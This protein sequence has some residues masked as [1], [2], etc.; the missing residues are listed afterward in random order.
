MAKI[1]YGCRVPGWTADQWNGRVNI[2]F[3]LSYNKNTNETTVIFTADECYH[4]Y[5]GLNGWGTEA[6]TG[7]TI[8]AADNTSDKKTGWL[9]T[10]GYTTGGLKQFNATPNNITVKHS[11]AIG[12]KSIVIEASTTIKVY[13]NKNVQSTGTG[14]Y[15][16]TVALPA[17][18]VGQPTSFTTSAESIIVPTGSI[19]LSWSGA[20]AGIN[21][22]IIGYW[23]YWKE[24]SKPTVSSYGG[25]AKIDSTAT[26]GSHIFNFSSSARTRGSTI[27][28]AILVKGFSGENYEP[29]LKDGPTV[30]INSLPA[31]PALSTMSAALPSTA[32][33]YSVKVTAGK[34][35]DSSQIIQV[36]LAADGETQASGT[37]FS[38]KDAG[39]FTFYSF[40]GLENSATGTSITIIRNTKP[41]V[42]S[43]S[44]VFSASVNTNDKT[45]STAQL[46]NAD[47]KKLT[48][49]QW[50]IRSASTS[51][52]VSSA[53]AKQI[54]TGTI[55]NSSSSGSS[56]CTLIINP[57]A[58]S[59][60]V[61]PGYYYQI[62]VQLKDEYEYSDIK[63][64]SDI[65]QI[66][67]QLSLS[68]NTITATHSETGMSATYASYYRAPKINLNWKS[69]STFP[70]GLSSL[71]YSVFYSIDAGSSWK[72][73]S[74]GIQS[75]TANT[76]YTPI[77]DFSS[78]G[79]G[80]FLAK[81][82]LYDKKDGS[83]QRLETAVS[84]K[85][86][87]AFDPQWPV[88]FNP[89]LAYTITSDD[90]ND[91]RICA[92]PNLKK[93]DGTIYNIN[94]LSL[95]V[96]YPS[97][98]NTILQTNKTDLQ[99]AIYLYQDGS[100]ASA[101]VRAPQKISTISSVTEAGPVDLDI[102]YEELGKCYSTFLDT[103]DTKWIGPYNMSIVVRF[104]DAFG[105][106]IDTPKMSFVLDFREK[107]QQITTL[108]IGRDGVLSNDYAAVAAKRSANTVIFPTGSTNAERSILVGEHLIIA[109]Q[110]PT[111]SYAA[112]SIGQYIFTLY[113][114]EGSVIYTYRTANIISA[115][116]YGESSLSCVVIPAADFLSTTTTFY[117]T[118]RQQD[119]Q[120][121]NDSISAESN[122][123]NLLCGG[124][125]E[126]PTIN[127]EM[128]DISPIGSKLNVSYTQSTASLSW[129]GVQSD[130]YKA[131]LREMEYTNVEYSASCKMILQ[132]STSNDFS[133]VEEIELASS[134]SNYALKSGSG[135]KEINLSGKCFVRLKVIYRTGLKLSAAGDI[136]TNQITLYSTPK[137][138][139]SEAPT[140]SY[141][142][143]KV[144]IN[145]TP[146]DNTAFKVSMTQNNN[147][148]TFEGYQV[149]NPSIIHSITF[150]LSQGKIISTN[151]MAT[152]DEID[153]I[154]NGTYVNARELTY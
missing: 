75:L 61:S 125:L 38:L 86:F 89:T 114:S 103:A 83:N 34:D 4:S 101:Q 76:T 22:S 122:E 107:P 11:S 135:S 56:N 40:D 110:K 119:S 100:S 133:S 33:A 102:K 49:A 127:F 147:L 97:T 25:I 14:S 149:S 118:I 57:L 139:F 35:S 79:R 148:I 47:L 3:E 121:Y 6:T 112:Q 94:A 65:K 113:N 81:I 64:A 137:I 90:A 150:D 9:Y 124:P 151:F 132:L 111:L 140:V 144:G 23:L 10:Y 37:Q 59:P 136:E 43:I 52:G 115:S 99:Y 82:V 123:S 5:Y 109:F 7:I 42:D 145:G 45:V 54:T 98:I 36:R 78:V 39:T 53:T 17:T 46:K 60:I 31:A 87:Y 152:Q 70:T 30:K 106:S 26:S 13:L 77:I 28:T 130:K 8:Y 50:Y 27:Y 24:G 72:Q 126:Q 138:Y 88:G 93:S 146:D 141:R 21:N 142:Q 66:Y 91:G 131:Y 129:S 80:D 120:S 51:A 116:I 55:T 108:K 15:S 143:N 63:W 71:W 85:L 153:E 58:S 67:G 18:P 12:A 44:T 32:G 128:P 68:L 19:P 92:R 73:W 62:G 95:S 48:A 154:C 104:F 74:N 69:P 105:T 117:A 2:G 134:A 41:E 20:T 1:N 96:P 29:D 84:N 16:D